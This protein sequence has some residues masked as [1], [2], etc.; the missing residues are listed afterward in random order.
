MSIDRRQFTRIEAQFPISLNTSD[1]RQLEGSI[2]NLSFKGILARMNIPQN[3]GDGITFSI[4]LGSG[5]A[6]AAI[7][8]EAEVVRELPDGTVGLKLT[9]LDGENLIRFRWLIEPH[10]GDSEAARGELRSW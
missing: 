9:R 1:G 4:P 8:G 2:L 3:I 6:D 10:L 5:E 7:Q